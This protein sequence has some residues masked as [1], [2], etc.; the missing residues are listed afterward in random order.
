MKKFILLASILFC[1][2]VYA[3]TVSVSPFISGNDVTISH[4]EA[5]RTTFSNALNGGIEGGINI[6]GGSI[7]SQDLSDAISPIT[8]WGEAFSDFTFSGMLPVTSGTLS[9]TTSAGVSYVNGYRLVIGATAHTYTASKDTY[10]YVHQGGYYVY[11]E[12][13]NGAAAPSTPVDT[14][15][16]AKVV[17]SGTAIT[18]VTDMRTTSI[19]ITVNTTNFASDYRDNAYVSWDSTTAFHVEPGQI[20]IGNSNYTNTTST[21]SR[22]ISTATNWIEG[23]V[24][25]LTS[26]RKIYVYGY[27]NSGTTF[28]FKYSSADPVYADMSLNTTGPLR[29]YVTGGTNYR[30]IGWVFVSADAV[31]SFAFGQVA[32]GQTRNR[33]VRKTAQY[34]ALGNATI[35]VDNTIPQLTEGQGLGNLDTPFVP[36]NPKAMIRVEIQANIS[37]TGSDISSV[38]A[39][40]QDTGVNA[41]AVRQ[42][43]T[44][45]A[46]C[47][48]LPLLYESTA[49][50]IAL[51]QFRPRVGNSTNAATF[52][53]GTSSLGTQVFGGVLESEIVIEEIS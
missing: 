40:F 2:N 33:V 37:T 34:V 30:A 35:P 48:V 41:I 12:V 45:D 31:Q 4:L 10:V 26:P 5:Q 49:G 27:N 52:I 11:Q 9:T 14:L 18:S 13:A 29:Y 23:G 28:D 32:D 7:V 46:A 53:N 3:G 51:K 42:T 16:L 19:Q 20:A 43:E 50:S 36:T 38:L 15:L 25:P 44:T 24:P 17:S 1:T 22:S 39:L 47:R 6:K 8:R 21:T